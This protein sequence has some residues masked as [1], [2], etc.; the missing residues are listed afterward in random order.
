VQGA[1]V[2]VWLVQWQLAGSPLH[3]MACLNTEAALEV[4]TLLKT[5]EEDIVRDRRLSRRSRIFVSVAA[6]GVVA[7][8]LIAISLALSLPRDLVHSTSLDTAQQFITKGSEPAFLTWKGHSSEC[9]VTP[10]GEIHRA[11]ELRACHGAYGEPDKFLVPPGGLGHV[12]PSRYPDLCL[13]APPDSTKVEMVRCDAP[14]VKDRITWSVPTDR[15][16]QFRLA[17]SPHTCVAV[18]GGNTPGSTSTLQQ[19][20]CSPGLAASNEIF[21]IHWPMDCRWELW[22][23]WTR[24]SMQCGGGM[25]KRSRFAEPAE[26]DGRGILCKAAETEEEHCNNQPCS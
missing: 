15:D 25:R 19:R 23:E 21:V 10:W 26:L 12:R 24:C 7:I 9:W 3:L 8:G 17:S 18:A 4:A 11:I 20:R 16:G 5:E 14:G 6:L 22:A 2:E 1:Q 13:Y